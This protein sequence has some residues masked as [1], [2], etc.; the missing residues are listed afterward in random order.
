LVGNFRAVKKDNVFL[1]FRH[2]NGAKIEYSH[3]GYYLAKS[4]LK[5]HSIS[6][7]ALKVLDNENKQGSRV[8][9]IE[10]L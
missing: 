5:M 2:K 3:M 10:S 4:L 9:S 8:V 6:V 7:N 1:A